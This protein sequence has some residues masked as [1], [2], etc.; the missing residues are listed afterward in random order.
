MQDKYNTDE[1]KIAFVLGLLDDG[2]AHTWRTN[3]LRGARQNGKFS[4]GSYKNFL[5]KLDD[6]FKRAN[7]EQEALFQLHQMKQRNDETADQTI[8]R[9]REQASLAGVSLTD[10][11]LLAIDY[12]RE[13]LN[14]RLVEKISLDVNEPTTFEEWVKLVVKYDNVWRRSKVMKGFKGKRTTFTRGNLRPFTRTP[15][16]DPDA[17]DVDVMTTEEREKLMKSG[18]CFRCK[19][20][21]HLAKD[22]TKKAT[23]S[24]NR[25]P[26]KRTP[27]EAARYIRSILAQYTPEEEQEIQKAA[28]EVGD[29]DF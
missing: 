28:E 29:E 24:Q 17:M 26:Q 27:K 11:P 18:A 6:T 23:T 14:P 9:F 1:K 19:E 15:A 13:V 20:R 10:N 21:G 3:F 25:E 5:Q 12:L 16:R 4:F 22:C 8:T 2:E 7:E